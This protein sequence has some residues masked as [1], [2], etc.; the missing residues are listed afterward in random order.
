MRVGLTGG[1]GAGKSTVARVL[2]SC[3]AVVVDADVVAR[4]VVAP[5]TPGLAA[6][7]DAFGPDIRRP[8]GSLDRPAL[9]AKAF[10]DDAA[11]ATLNAITHPLVGAR[12]AELIAAAPADAI[13]VQ[14]IPLLVE[15]QLGSLFQLVI[16]V[17][18]DVDLRV[19]RL[20]EHRGVEEADARSRIAAQATDDQR[21]AAADVLLDNGGA[22]GALDAPLR[23]LFTQRLM[24]FERNLRERRRVAARYRLVEPNPDWPAQ[25]RRLIGRLAVVCGADALRI[26]HIGSTAVPGL[27][28]K[29]VVDLQITVGDLAVADSLADRLADIGFPRID[30]IVADNPHPTPGDLDGVDRARWSKRVHAAADPGRP[31]NIHIRVADSPGGQ[32]ALNVRDWLR[33]DP[34]ARAEYLEVKR[35]AEAAAAVAGRGVGHDAAVAYLAVK[36]PW[37]DHIYPT[38]TDWART[39]AMGPSGD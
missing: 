30:H 33:T 26:D 23:E 35:K 7:V 20:V 38:V 34:A 22:A 8:D 18:A 24:P 16:V 19:R 37:F 6:L 27:A 39:R 29:D 21:R 4:E 28:A 11:R 17:T 15:N 2:A 10:G 31:A 25:A 1:M 13:V 9:A 5:G 3:G 14:D 36:Q 12:T 32:F